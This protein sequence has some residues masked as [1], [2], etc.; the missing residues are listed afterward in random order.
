MSFTARLV[1]VLTAAAFLAGCFNTYHLQPDEFARLQTDAEVPL[2]VKADDGTE[3]LVD[4]QTSISVVSAGGR[5]YPVTAFNFKMTGSQLVASDR[6][7]LLMLDEVADYDVQLLSTP[8]TV[9][10]IAAGVVLAGGLI[11]FTISSADK[12]ALGGGE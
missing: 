3:I 8:K 4:R 9:L 10:L 7:T 6:D 2:V 11:A 1:A 12:K 5:R